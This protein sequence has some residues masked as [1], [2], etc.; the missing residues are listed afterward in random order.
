MMFKAE[1]NYGYKPSLVYVRHAQ[2][3]KQQKY[4]QEHSVVS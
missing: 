1:N 3:Q 2:L 4:F